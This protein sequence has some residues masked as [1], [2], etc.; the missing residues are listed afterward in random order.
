MTTQAIADEPATLGKRAA[1]RGEIPGIYWRRRDGWIVF[2][3]GLGTAQ[4]ETWRGKGYEALPEYGKQPY[5]DEHRQPYR[6]ILQ[7]GGSHEF[8]IEQIVQHHWHDA[9]PYGLSKKSFPQLKQYQIPEPVY[10]DEC[11][12]ERR[13]AF[14]K[15]LRRHAQIAHKYRRDDVEA[16][17]LRQGRTLNEL[18][19]IEAKTVPMVKDEK[20]VN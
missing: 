12:P 6:L 5:R 10:C 3:P 14:A 17:L 19:V 15:H 16:M 1:A 9:P 20:E 2:G 11:T 18:D 7:A 4:A 8:P 13:F